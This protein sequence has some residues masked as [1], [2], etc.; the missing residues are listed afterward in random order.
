MCVSSTNER[1]LSICFWLI[2]NYHNN[3]KPKNNPKLKYIFDTHSSRIQMANPVPFWITF[4]GQ[5][6]YRRKYPCYRSTVISLLRTSRPACWRM[7]SSDNQLPD[8]FR[9]DW[10]SLRLNLTRTPAGVGSFLRMMINRFLQ[11][12]SIPS[13]TTYLTRSR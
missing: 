8:L 10:L 12:E 4:S 6:R 9:P 7:S 2:I 5:N 1:F 13:G 3:I 11:Y